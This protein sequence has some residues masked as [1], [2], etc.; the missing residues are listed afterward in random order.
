MRKLFYTLALLAAVSLASGCAHSLTVK[1]LDKY[2]TFTANSLK[3]R[4]SIGIAPVGQTDQKLL[5][6]IAGQLGTF[7]ANVV[8]PYTA[9]AK[10]ADVV[11]AIAVD[12]KYEGSGWNFLINFPGFLVFAPAWHGY[13]YEVSHTINV[14]LNRGSDNEQIDTF[15][16]PVVLD[17][18][19]ADIDRTWTEISWFEVGAIAFVG[20]IIFVQYDDDVTPLLADKISTPIGTYVAQEIVNRINR[21]GGLGKIQPKEKTVT[22]ESESSSVSERLLDLK[23]L[24][25]EGILTDDEYQTKRAELIKGL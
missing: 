8:M 2:Q 20:G 21:Y 3:Q 11:A 25:D 10:Q 15:T 19:H 14:Q 4:L 9:S 5:N 13:V 18:R 17:I 1:N 6:G 22:I 7:Q 24:K 12:S 16:I 23:K